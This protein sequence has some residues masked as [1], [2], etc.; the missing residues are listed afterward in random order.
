MSRIAWIDT[1]GHPKPN[2][3]ASCSPGVPSDS[4]R[5][6]GTPHPPH[7][8]RLGVNPTVVPSFE[9]TRDLAPSL[10]G[11]RGGPQT[12]QGRRH[13][14]P[15]GASLR[16]GTLGLHD[17]TA[18]RFDEPH[19]VDRHDRPSQAQRACVMQPR[20][21]E[22]QRVLSG[23]L[24]STP[25]SPPCCEPHRGS[26]TR[27]I[28]RPRSTP[29]DACFRQNDFQ[30]PNHS[31]IHHFAFAELSQKQKPHETGVP[32]G[33]EG[34]FED[35]SISATKPRSSTSSLFV[36]AIFDLAKSSIS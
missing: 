36:A 15:K 30:K 32:W 20:S 25:R 34:A 33:L 31:A 9:R 29:T 21:A 28:A 5:S 3:L 26:V 13:L 4:E 17:G 11:P 19:R 7:D 35:Y 12:G 1:T 10:T 27:T 24:A 2:G 16:L 23:D 14:I 6:P 8:P 22:R 18:W